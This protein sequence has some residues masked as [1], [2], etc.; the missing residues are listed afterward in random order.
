MKINKAYKFR[1]SPNA[2]QVVILTSL[3][4]SARF[5]WNEMLALSLEMFAKNEFINAINLVNKIVGLKNNPE[6]AFFE[7]PI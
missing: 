3:V 7:I 1:L 2:E 6:F 4:D 5:V